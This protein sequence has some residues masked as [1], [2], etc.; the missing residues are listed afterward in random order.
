MIIYHSSSGGSP[1]QQQRA[2]KVIWILKTSMKCHLKCIS[3]NPNSD[4]EYLIKLQ[5]K[6]KICHSN[7]MKKKAKQDLAPPMPPKPQTQLPVAHAK[8]KACLLL[9]VWLRAQDR[10]I[11]VPKLLWSSNKT[12]KQK[13]YQ[14]KT[15]KKQKPKKH[16]PPKKR[17]PT[18]EALASMTSLVRNRSPNWIVVLTKFC[19]TALD[20]WI[21]P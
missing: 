7:I 20:F 3:Y 4:C 9:V 2:R 6:M 21:P 12:N 15:P 8:G 10:G 16:T 11:S 13:Q 14:K 17:V 1:L 18:S 19:R 5:Y